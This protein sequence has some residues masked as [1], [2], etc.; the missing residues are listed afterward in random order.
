MREALGVSS[1]SIEMDEEML[2][3]LKSLGYV[4]DE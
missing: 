1:P 2:E 4:G 3:R